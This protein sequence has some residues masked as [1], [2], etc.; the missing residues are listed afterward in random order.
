MTYNEQ[1]PFAEISTADVDFWGYYNGRNNPYSYITPTTINEETS[2]EVI[3]RP[4]RNPDWRYGILGCLKRIEYPTKGFTEFIYE[5]NEAKYIILR[6]KS[7]AFSDYIPPTIDTLDINNQVHYDAH[8]EKL[9]LY[10]SV[11]GVDK[12]TGGVRVKKIIDNDG[13]NNSRHR[14]FEYIDGAVGP[15]P[16]FWMHKT[17]KYDTY[18][19]YVKFANESFDRGHIGYNRV[20]EKFSD[21]SYVEYEFTNYKT[22]PNEYDGQFEGRKK[23]L[24]PTKFMYYMEDSILLNNMSRIPNSR[25]LHRGKLT[26]TAYYDNNNRKVKCEY[27]KYADHNSISDIDYTL[28]VNLSCV[29]AYPVRNYTGDYRLTEKTVTEYF[30]TDSIIT[31]TTLAYNALGQISSTSVHYP[32]GK[33]VSDNTEYLYEFSSLFGSCNHPII[34]D[35]PY[36]K[37]RMITEQAGTRYITSAT[38]ISY[39]TLGYT[40]RVMVKPTAV[41]D[42]E[43][44]NA[45]L[46]QNDSQVFPN[47]NYKD[48]IRYEDYDSK[49]NPIQVVDASGVRTSYLWGYGGLYPVVKAVNMTSDVLKAKLG[50]TDHNPLTDGLPMPTE[51]D[52]FPLFGIEGALVDLYY[53]EPHVG[54]TKHCDPSQR[55]HYFTYDEFSRLIK[56][57][58]G[59]GITEK[60]EYHIGE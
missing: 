54:M 56:K 28:S 2:E 45:V 39:S 32:D 59:V 18:N 22:H 31:R 6:S 23:M 13:F 29:Y 14:E 52:N 47:L 50:I 48:K 12:G 37:Y 7:T 15:F 1:Y 21:H 42:A 24:D 35:L 41:R 44:E 25:H 40:N 27:Y 33:T 43:I 26:R 34:Y 8:L 20:R 51:R 60:Y 16:R 30:G 9:N 49:G 17:G 10:S 58:D 11:F 46:W 4:Y 19:P 3:D 5:P 53:Y 38:K 57:R 36:R 55:W